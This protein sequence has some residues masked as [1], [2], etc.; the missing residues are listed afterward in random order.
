VTRALPFTQAS[1]KR[2]IT[3]ARK[4]GLTVVGIGPDGTVLVHDRENTPTVVR[5]SAQSSTVDKRPLAQHGK[6]IL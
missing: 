2:A 6:I 5:L 3:A 1:I 4:A